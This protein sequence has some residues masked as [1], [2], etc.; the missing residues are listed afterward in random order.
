MVFDSLVISLAFDC[1][2]FPIINL[3][4]L[5]SFT[6][7]RRFFPPLL[8][9]IFIIFSNQSLSLLRTTAT[10]CT[11]SCYE[12]RAFFWILSS[13]STA[14]IRS[15]LLLL[16]NIIIILFICIFPKSSGETS[17]PVIGS[18]GSSFAL[19]IYV[20][21]SFLVF[22]FVFSLSLSLSC[23]SRKILAFWKNGDD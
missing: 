20:S 23:F 15:L 2:K 22:V 14:I 1:K 12:V 21:I 11:F 7:R 18:H 8:T 16:L 3:H 17:F 4:Y 9:N 6:N 5:L 19:L 13:W 10:G